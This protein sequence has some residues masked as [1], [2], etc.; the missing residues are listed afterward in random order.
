MVVMLVMVVVFD[1]GGGG[2]SG[3]GHSS[4]GDG[5]EGRRTYG[6]EERTVHCEEKNRS[7]SC[8]S[9]ARSERKEGLLLSCI[10]PT[11]CV[12][13]GKRGNGVKRGECKG[14]G[15]PEA[16]TPP[17]DSSTTDP[18]HHSFPPRSRHSPPLALQDPSRHSPTCGLPWGTLSQQVHPHP[19]KRDH[20]CGR[21]DRPTHQR[22]PAP[23]ISTQTPPQ[24]PV[25]T[26]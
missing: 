23:L 26:S 6:R 16:D 24:P 18:Q 21:R 25:A 5:D 17:A 12:H 9:A 1:D 4:A 14:R 20:S 19:A 3:G 13:D 10:S 22:A 7:H 11:F 2:D 15:R 8:F